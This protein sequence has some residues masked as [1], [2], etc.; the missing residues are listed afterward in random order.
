VLVVDG[1][2]VRGTRPDGWWR[3]K[4]AAMHRLYDRLCCLHER[5]RDVVVLV[6]DVA[7][8]DLPE[9]DDGAVEVVTAPHPGRDA[10][11]R[12]ILELLVQW[13]G[14]PVEVV[15]SDRALA[16]AARR[17]GV[18]VTGAGAFLRRLDELGC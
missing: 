5:T 6:L 13:A 14:E 9:G 15:T 12:R 17:P 11:D 3:D 8:P 18:D 2:N 10:A 7:Q 1:S 16:D 4:P